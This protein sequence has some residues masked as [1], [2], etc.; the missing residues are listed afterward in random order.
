MLLQHKIL[1]KSLCQ[2]QY[3]TTP[4]SKSDKGKIQYA[5][6]MKVKNIKGRILYATTTEFSK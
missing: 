3:A 5:T 4:K 1:K 6:T 2:V